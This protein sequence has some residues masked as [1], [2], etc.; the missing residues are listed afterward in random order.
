M[1]FDNRGQILA[2]MPN[3]DDNDRDLLAYLPV[4]RTNTLY[5]RVG[6]VTAYAAIL[7]LLLSLFIAGRNHV[8]AR[9]RAFEARA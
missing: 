9:K 2:A 1:A 7:A 8:E 4:G 3:F 5:S 6:N